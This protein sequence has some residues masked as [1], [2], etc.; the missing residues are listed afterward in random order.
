MFW[1]AGFLMESAP[2]FL[3]LTVTRRE[4]FWYTLRRIVPPGRAW[5]IGIIGLSET[6]PKRPK[7]TFR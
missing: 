2:S 3:S 5:D 4:T 6:V 7:A 1:Y